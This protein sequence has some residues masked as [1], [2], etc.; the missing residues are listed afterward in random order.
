GKATHLS[1][2][3]EPAGSDRVLAQAMAFLEQQYDVV[4]EAG[5]AIV[6]RV[7]QLRACPAGEPEPVTE[8]GDRLDIVE[9]ERQRDDEG[10][11][12]AV[13]EPRVD[14]ARGVFVKEE[15]QVRIRF[16]DSRQ[17]RWQQERR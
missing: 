12:I 7:D 11:E 5:E 10:V 3:P 2:V 6:L 14:F 13:Q 16:P 4:L 1:V 15:T 8:Q 9:I 17:N